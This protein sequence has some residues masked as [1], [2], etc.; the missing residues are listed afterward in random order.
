MKK[1]LISLG[2]LCLKLTKCVTIKYTFYEVIIDPYD[3]E[4]LHLGY[5]LQ[6]MGDTTFILRPPTVF[7]LQKPQKYD[8]FFIVD[9]CLLTSLEHN[10]KISNPMV[11]SKVV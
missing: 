4:R 2:K 3:V 6:K 11:I 7:M 5:S 10:P 8:L 1:V 9:I